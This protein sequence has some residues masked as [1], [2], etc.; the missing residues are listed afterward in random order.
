MVKSFRLR[1]PVR[2]E[3]AWCWLLNG[4]FLGCSYIKKNW[5]W[6]FECTYRVGHA[7]GG[8]SLYLSLSLSLSLPVSFSVSLSLSPCRCLCDDLR[9]CFY[10]FRGDQKARRECHFFTRHYNCTMLCDRCCA[11][12]PAKTVVDGMN[13]KNFSADAPFL[14]TTIDH[15]TYVNTTPAA[16][17]SP[18]TAMPGWKIENTFFDWMH[19]VLLGVAKDVA[20]AAIKLMVMRGVM[21][22]LKLREEL[23]ALTTWIKRERK[24]ETGQLVWGIRFFSKF[25]SRVCTFRCI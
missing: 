14:L 6:Q 12:K 19:V 25:M 17:L 13:Y 23:K 21:S 22:G 3:V 10:G 24:R 18:W 11:M 9:A 15:D 5:D 20:A 7:L 8:R 4:R 1:R 2:E 16:E